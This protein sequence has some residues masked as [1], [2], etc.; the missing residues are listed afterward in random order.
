MVSWACFDGTSAGLPCRLE[1]QLPAALSKQQRAF[2]HGLAQPHAP[3]LRKRGAQETRIKCSASP[4]LSFSWL[5]RLVCHGYQA[6]VRAQLGLCK[7][8][9]RVSTSLSQTAAVLPYAA[10]LC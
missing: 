3:E 4:N 2:W 8:G 6:H 7:P 10:V 1:L 5:N 9:H